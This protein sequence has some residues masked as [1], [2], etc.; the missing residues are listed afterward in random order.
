MGGDESPHTFVDAAVI[1]LQHHPF[2]HIILFGDQ[3]VIQAALHHLDSQSV[4]TR[5]TIRH[6][7]QF[8]APEDKPSLALRH[9]QKSS[10]WMALTAVAEGSAQAILS[11]GNTGALMAMA[12][13]VLGSLEG[14]DR[15]AICKR[16]PISRSVCYV[17][18][19]GA[20][21]IADVKQLQDFA[22][23]GAALVE[24]EGLSPARVGLL[25]VG[26]ELQKGTDLL[27]DANES[28]KAATRFQ[29][30]GFVEGNA[31]FDGSVNVVVCDGFSGN[32]A[33][34][35]CEGLARYL[36][37][38]LHSYFAASWTKRLLGTLIKI[39]ANG[40]FKRLNPDAYNG[41][42]LIGLNGIVVKSHG[43]ANRAGFIAA[44]NVAADLA[45]R[46]PDQLL[47]RWLSENR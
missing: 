17:L 33:L 6:A 8:V 45:Q 11:P 32:V 41:A 20:N 21:L 40:W 16:M 38:D 34:K 26:Q 12:R 30:L 10:M 47:T 13:H 3:A 1:F 39:L 35:A 5:L 23:L 18:D 42:L 29:Y 37:A 14:I 22:L 28:L 43:G 46:R 27:Q 15:P 36:A 25:N 44:L 31:I 4:S 9:K 24:A 2:V 19:L 7:E